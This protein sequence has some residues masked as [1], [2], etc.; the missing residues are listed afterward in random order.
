M[1]TY[2]SHIVLTYKDV[3][4][5][6]A[7]SVSPKASSHTFY[8]WVEGHTFEPCQQKAFFKIIFWMDA[9]THR[10]TDKPK[11]ICFHFFKVQG[12]DMEGTQIF[13]Y[14]TCSAGRVTYNFHSSCEHM[15]LS[16]KS[17]CN[18]GHR[19]VICNMTSLSNSSQSAG[20]VG[21]VLW[22]E[23]LVLSRFHS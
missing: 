2:I 11:P 13:K 9:L 5:Q 18:K 7:Q 19:G 16:F 3:P 21:W 15:H 1:F 10:H 8:Q 23:L 6:K 20:S 12:I 17:V 22:E 14:C 4:A